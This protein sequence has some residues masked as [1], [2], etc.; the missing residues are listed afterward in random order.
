MHDGQN[1]F[2]KSTSFA[3]VIWDVHSSIEYTMVKGKTEGV[4]VVALDNAWSDNEEGVVGRFD[5]F[6]PWIKSEATNPLLKNQVTRA[7]GGYGKEYAKYIVEELKPLID[8]RYRTKTDRENTGIAGSGMGALI[9]L[10]MALTYEDVFSK[11]G[12]FSTDVWFAEE[13]LL[14][15]IRE[16]APDRQIKWYLDIGSQETSHHHIE[17]FHDIYVKGTMEVYE[18][19]LQAGVKEADIKILVDEG[20][21]H[22]EEAWARRFQSAF[23]WLYS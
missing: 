9:S 6:S 7:V 19:L 15:L 5:E 17:N 20:A 13:E 21:K 22:H 3:G 11:I 2:D 23:E 1:L 14:R 4:I 18:S 12:A 16:H 10:Y 8:N